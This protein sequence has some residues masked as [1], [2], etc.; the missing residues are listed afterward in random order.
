MV[1]NKNKW[2]NKFVEGSYELLKNKDN[3]LNLSNSEIAILLNARCGFNLSDGYI[4]NIIAF[5]RTL[6][7]GCF[8]GL[9]DELQA[10][11]MDIEDNFDHN[12]LGNIK[13]KDILAKVGGSNNLFQQAMGFIEL[14]NAGVF[15]GDGWHNY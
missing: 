1:K 10:L 11:I 5:C 13:N 12:E 15:D 14:E 4:N 8:D 2:S 9:S 3:W 7:N 6:A